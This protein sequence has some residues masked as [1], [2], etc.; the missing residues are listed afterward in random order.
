MNPNAFMNMY[1]SFK[2]NPMQMLSTRFNIPSD[3][4]EPNEI[5][6]HLLNTGQVTQAQVNQVMSMRNNPMIRQLIGK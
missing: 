5:I 6:N 2:T 3:M 4:K 1:Q